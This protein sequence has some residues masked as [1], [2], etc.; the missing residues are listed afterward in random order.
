[1]WTVLE[2]RKHRARGKVESR[3][4]R[5]AEGTDQQAEG[6]EPA[7]GRRTENRGHQPG[8]QH[9]I[10][11]RL[12]A[13]ISIG[14][15]ALL[16]ALGLRRQ[17]ANE[18]LQRAHGADPAAEKPPQKERRQQDNQAP[19]Q[20]AIEGVAG[21]RIDQGHQRVPL[22]KQPHRR[23]QMN[24]AASAGRGSVSEV[25]ISSARNRSRK[26][27][28]EILRHSGNLDR[29]TTL[30]HTPRAGAPYIRKMI[31]AEANAGL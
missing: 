11:A 25:K 3:Q 22:E 16:A 1:M 8:D 14:I 20:A 30:L 9:H 12:P 29:A 24:L 28:C 4:Q 27:I 7:D 23:A 15:N 21:Q 6:I 31:A 5:Q 19:D 13:L 2:R 18:V 26:K 10:F 17:T